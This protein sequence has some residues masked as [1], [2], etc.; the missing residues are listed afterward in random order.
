M[1]QWAQSPLEAD[2]WYRPAAFGTLYAFRQHGGW[3]WEVRMAPSRLS[4]DQEAAGSQRDAQRLA[5]W[6]YARTLTNELEDF[7]WALGST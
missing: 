1:S 2:S 3:V 7:K 4:S 5:E 6:Y